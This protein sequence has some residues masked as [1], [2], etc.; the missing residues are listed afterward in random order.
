MGIVQE[1]FLKQTF[2]PH[3]FI[4]YLSLAW[5]RY[6]FCHWEHDQNKYYV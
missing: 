3:G 1:S 5:Y 4:C 2:Q 6:G